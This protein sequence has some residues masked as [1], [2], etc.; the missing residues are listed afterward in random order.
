MSQPSITVALPTYNG[1]AT[2]RECLESLA[3]Q[4]CDGFTV[5]IWDNASSDGTSEICA[6]FA[7]ADPRFVHHRRPENIGSERNFIE[8]L[9]A[10][11]TPYFLWRA[12]DDLADPD[13]LSR[14]RALLE[15]SPGAALA[16]S[17]VE[18]RRPARGRVRTFPFPGVLPGPRVA[19]I[20]RRM[21]R[22]HQS[23]IYCLWRTERLRHYYATTWEAYPV[24]WANDHLLLLN[25]ILDDAV[26]GDDGVRFIQRIDVRR[27]PGE[28]RRVASLSERIAQKEALLPRFRALCRDAVARREWS[29]AERWVLDRVIDAYARK[30]VN[31]SELE[32]WLLKAQRALRGLLRR[33]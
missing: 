15:A 14:M 29:A 30:R 21:F 3:A 23:W 4:G 32:I 1:A 22:S 18:A 11:T 20:V 12:D 31:A 25:V 10:T 13:F 33:T 19:T 2:I 16:A 5:Q 9:E 17:R 26:V 24:G 27:A 7:A 6:A 8:A 28:A